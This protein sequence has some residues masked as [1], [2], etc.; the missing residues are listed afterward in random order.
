MKLHRLDDIRETA[1]VYPAD[2][3][4]PMS[5]RQLLERWAELLERHPGPVRPLHEIEY[6]AEGERAGMR[7]DDSA[8]AIA[9]ADPVLRL[10]G[11]AS[12]RYEDARRF[13]DLTASEAHLLLCDCHTGASL[14]GRAAAA[15]VRTI[16]N[17]SAERSL[18]FVG[19]I[20]AAALAAGALLS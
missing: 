15:R 1:A 18:A 5:R 10:Q 12:D 6:A 7:C 4:A 20:T 2:A 8:I 9:Y 11:L 16:A 17:G 14:S 13:F 3:A 19:V